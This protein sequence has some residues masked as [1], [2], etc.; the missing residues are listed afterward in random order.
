MQ[1][2][3]TR[4]RNF[5][6]AYVFISL[7]L[8]VIGVT[9]LEAVCPLDSGIIAEA[10]NH[11]LCHKKRNIP[12]IKRPVLSH[13]LVFTG[14]DLSADAETG[15][16]FLDAF[17]GS[18]AFPT[19]N[20]PFSGSPTATIAFRI[21]LTYKP[22]ELANINLQF[23]TAGNALSG[24]GDVSI[25]VN[26]A[27]ARSGQPLNDG[28]PILLGGVLVDNVISGGTVNRY[29]AANVFIGKKVK[30]GDFVEVTII[31]NNDVFDAGHTNLNADIFL[32]GVSLGSP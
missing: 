25:I 14:K 6:T 1:N 5:L 32:C 18:F 11:F 12:V 28:E 22:R 16:I 10:S 19:I 9:G 20:L 29:Y 27:I 13:P 23:M 7:S 15:A 8:F 4:I 3:K 31:R 30:P 17:S 21:P 24:I 26:G 2:K